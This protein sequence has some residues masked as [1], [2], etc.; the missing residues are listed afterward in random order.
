MKPR[1]NGSPEERERQGPVLYEATKTR[2]HLQL[3]L[4]LLLPLILLPRFFFRSQA[5]DRRANIAAPVRELHPD[6][7][8][9][10]EASSK[11]R[12]I[13]QATVTAGGVGG[14]EGEGAVSF[15][16]GILALIQ[17]EANW[18]ADEK[19]DELFTAKKLLTVVATS[20]LH[21]QFF[22]LSLCSSY[23]R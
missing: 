6:L 9:P 22:P 10:I 7:N 16:L 14:W 23:V 13:R 3:D 21:V 15:Q 17:M 20:L 12:T 8:D 11:A 19:T 4:L 2:R 1:S 5:V 18:R